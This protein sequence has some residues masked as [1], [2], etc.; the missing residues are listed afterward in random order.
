MEISGNVQKNDHTKSCQI[1]S[2]DLPT[3][4]TQEFIKSEP[5]YSIRV[6]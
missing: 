6:R 5:N 2:S 4:A 1:S 3:S